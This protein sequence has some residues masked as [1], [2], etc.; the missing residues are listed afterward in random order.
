MD[1]SETWPDIARPPSPLQN[2]E[3]G[4]HARRIFG[5]FWSFPNGTRFYVFM[6]CFLA[7]VGTIG[8]GLA[9]SVNDGGAFLLYTVHK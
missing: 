6:F 1:S 7:Q 8:K 9:H 3:T 5:V 4:R 2:I